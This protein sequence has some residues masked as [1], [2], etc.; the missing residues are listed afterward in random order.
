MHISQ[1]KKEEKERYRIR[2]SVS[3]S[4]IQSSEGELSIPNEDNDLDVRGTG[5]Y[6]K[7]RSIKEVICKEDPNI[8]VLQEAD[9]KSREQKQL[10]FSLG[11]R[12]SN[13]GAGRNCI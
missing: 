1:K 3:I 9:K 7:K 13:L 10:F 11:K 4:K 12:V 2:G 8:I 5:S 6:R